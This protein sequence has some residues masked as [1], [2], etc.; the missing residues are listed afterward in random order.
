VRETNTCHPVLPFQAL[1]YVPSGNLVS[2]VRRVR[3]TLGKKE[4]VHLNTT[5]FNLSSELKIRLDTLKLVRAA[6]NR[7]EVFELMA[8]ILSAGGTGH[9]GHA[10]EITSSIPNGTH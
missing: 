6:I 4:Y 5:V 3:D 7:T 10:S 1:N 9:N 2:A 8:G